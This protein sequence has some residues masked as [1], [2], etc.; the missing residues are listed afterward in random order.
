VPPGAGA[1]AGPTRERQQRLAAELLTQ[2]LLACVES[3]PPAPPG[4]PRSEPPLPAPTLEPR[5]EHLARLSAA[6]ALL[7]QIEL[8]LVAG[9]RPVLALTLDN[10]L[11]ARVEIERLGPGRVAIKLIGHRGPPPPEAVTAIRGSIEA[12]GLKVGAISVA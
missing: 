11:G 5:Q 9:R 7:A 8:F 6:T 2:E 4:A 12:H 3:C 1:S 10:A